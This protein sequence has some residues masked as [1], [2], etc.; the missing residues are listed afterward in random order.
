[1]KMYF[2]SSVNILHQRRKA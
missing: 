1:M 2:D